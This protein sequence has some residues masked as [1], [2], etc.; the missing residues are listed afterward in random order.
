MVVVIVAI[1]VMVMV[2]VP[3]VTSMV[4][5]LLVIAVMAEED[6]I[7]SL[8]YSYSSWWCWRRR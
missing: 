5:D 8:F 7:L 3:M 4:E 2:V 6:P 1:L